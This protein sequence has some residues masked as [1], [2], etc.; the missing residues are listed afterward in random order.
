MLIESPLQ[1]HSIINKY[2]RVQERT[3]PENI[4]AMLLK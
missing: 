4:V 2:V 1:I 3:Y